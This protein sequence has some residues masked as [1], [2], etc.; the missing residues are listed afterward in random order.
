V[1]HYGV[2]NIASR[3]ART[4]SF[5]IS[6]V[7]TPKLIKAGQIGGLET[8]FQTNDGTRHGIYLYKGTVANRHLSERFNLKYTDL[9]LIFSASQL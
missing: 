8:L 6:N 4:A 3:F 2:P 9:D 1:I 7:L 5:A